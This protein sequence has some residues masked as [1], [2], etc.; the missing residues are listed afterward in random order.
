MPFFKQSS[1]CRA[2]FKESNEK[3][4]Q[5][6]KELFMDFVQ[7]CVKQSEE[8][9]LLFHISFKDGERLNFKC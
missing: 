7:L 3:G 4:L 5:M 6:K 8:A 9:Q 1:G 2:H